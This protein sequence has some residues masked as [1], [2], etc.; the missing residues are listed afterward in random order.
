MAHSG[1]DAA[2]G[3]SSASTRYVSPSNA[4][5]L[6][7]TL[8]SINTPILEARS[9]SAG[10]LAPAP[11]LEATVTE[12]PSPM[13]LR[14]LPVS[15]LALSDAPSK[16]FR[17]PLISTDSPHGAGEP[18]RRST[19]LRNG[20]QRRAAAP[21][22]ARTIQMQQARR[23][24][25]ERLFRSKTAGHYAS[26]SEAVASGMLEPQEATPHHPDSGRTRMRE[27]DDDD[28]AH[29]K[30][31]RVNDGRALDAGASYE[32]DGAEAYDRRRRVDRPRHA[33]G[34]HGARRRGTTSASDSAVKWRFSARLEPPADDGGDSS[35]ESDEDREALT[36]KVPLSKIRGGELIGLSLRP[37]VSATTLT[38][39]VGPATVRPTG[40]GSTRTPVPIVTEA[41]PTPATL[42]APPA[43]TASAPTSF[44]LSAAPAPAKEPSPS[45][46]VPAALAATP[47]PA[48]EAKDAAA[49]EKPTST[50]TVEGAGAKDA[51]KTPAAAPAFS[52]GG[53]SARK[54]SSD[55]SDAAPKPTVPSFSIAGAASI[56]A[57]AAAAE[58]P[59]ATTAAPAFSFGLPKPAAADG[60]SKPAP[61][62][63]F[64][65]PAT[66]STSTPV[67]KFGAPSTGAAAPAVGA[68]TKPAPALKF[69]FG[70]S[71]ATSEAAG[72]KKNIFAV[73]GN[74]TPAASTASQP[75]LFA[76]SLST[77]GEKRPGEDTAP[78]PMFTFGSGG[79]AASG[80]FG[81]SAFSTS[82]PPMFGAAATSTAQASG[83]DSAMDGATAPKAPEAPAAPKPF[84]G[85]SFS[86]PAG[87]TSGA[88]ATFG[89]S[90]PFGRPAKTVDLTQGDTGMDTSAPPAASTVPAA[91]GMD[92]SPAPA[93]APASVFGSGFASFGAKPSFGGFGAAGTSAGSPASG[94]KPAP[95]LSFGGASTASSTAPA[96]KKPA[97]T[98][99]SLN[100]PSAASFA[101]TTV[102]TPTVPSF[103]S[104]AATT[105][106]SLGAPA[107]TPSA[108]NF[109]AASSPAA[110]PS[111]AGFSFGAK[112]A[113]PQA[114]SFGNMSSQP[115]GGFGSTMD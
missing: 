54:R 20:L 64:S 19:S 32:A 72:E 58:K 83:A 101:A 7:S 96:A 59:A 47:A 4:R 99:G 33:H 24:V 34:R 94:S 65:K 57:S 79:G 60:E 104:V 40:F 53:L 62:F 114:T 30:R 115:V 50:A 71:G 66:A 97:F 103:G 67:P 86:T 108:F 90:A 76:P 109:G 37:S 92:S 91:N 12:R 85:F 100:T 102:P 16:A 5:R 29:P 68:E 113:L 31:R 106:P 8:G 42:P 70:S 17:S 43:V 75:S 112:P 61:S 25:A 26:D 89:V 39:G 27:S 6:L 28:L 74:D 44:T 98:F 111:T 93:P 110:T 21:S 78:K 56:T 52:F 95:L 2:Y 69:T 41:A 55:D 84:G 22:L 87:S 23:A 49:A 80:V 48:A 88:A 46:S 107:A 36:A 45:A 105:A 13:P 1:H 9:R 11:R 82:K 81:A 10:G 18:P 73:P 35:S 63:Q 15:L 14:R 51:D 3:D 77:A 38:N